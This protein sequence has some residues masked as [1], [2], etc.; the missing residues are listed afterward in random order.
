MERERPHPRSGRPGKG[1][2]KHCLIMIQSVMVMIK[3]MMIEMIMTNTMMMVVA[4]IANL[5][6]QSSQY[7]TEET[8]LCSPNGL[9]HILPPEQDKIHHHYHHHHHRPLDINPLMNSNRPDM[10]LW[11]EDFCSYCVLIR[12]LVDDHLQKGWSV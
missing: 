1:N 2:A 10:S 7:K 11:R 12:P 9:S 6:P 8:L 3:V 4:V 5:S